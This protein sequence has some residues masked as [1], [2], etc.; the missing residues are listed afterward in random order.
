M[1]PLCQ[2]VQVI[3][4][5]G[6]AMQGALLGS[7]Y[8]KNAD[9]KKQHVAYKQH[10]NDIRRLGAR[11]LGVAGHGTVDAEPAHEPVGGVSPL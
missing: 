1:Q 6:I 5:N 3:G 4:I 9:A 8:V 11:I 2:R 10:R 7:H